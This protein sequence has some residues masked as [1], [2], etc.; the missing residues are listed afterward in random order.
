[1]AKEQNK[2]DVEKVREAAAAAAQNQGPAEREELEPPVDPSKPPQLSKEELAAAAA[3]TGEAFVVENEGRIICRPPPGVA[4]HT[5]G[6]VVLGNVVATIDGK[7]VTIK[8]GTPVR[9]LS[10]AIIAK[11]RRSPEVRVGRVPTPAEKTA[12]ANLGG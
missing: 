2:Q 9:G 12:A 7:S 8:H 6:N 4:L 5:L 3:L 10:P 1:M 11:L